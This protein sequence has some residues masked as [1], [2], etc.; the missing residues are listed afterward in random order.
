MKL[1]WQNKNIAKL[2][3]RDKTLYPFIFQTGSLTR[4]IQ[5]Q[6]RGSFHI[7]IKSETWQHPMTDEARLINTGE[8]E[9]AFIRESWLKCDDKALVYART[10]IPRRTLTGK[11]KKLT[12]LGT[13]PLGEILFAD[14]S[15]YRSDMRYARVPVDCALYSQ[16]LD[17][18]DV[19]S[20]LWARQ[21]LFYV[22]NEP[23]LIIEVFLPD[24]KE[25]IQS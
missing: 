2:H 24:I 3:I 21:S 10:V 18:Y 11:Y 15:S 22:K 6:C 16:V 9:P 7:E 8:R 1:R 5:Q 13:R 25:C 20:S 12:R 23:L 19:N 4:Y 14:K 17:T